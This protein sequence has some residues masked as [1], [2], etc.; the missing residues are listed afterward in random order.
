MVGDATRQFDAV[1][2]ANWTR[3]LPV[4]Q[5]RGLHTRWRFVAV[6]AAGGVVGTAARESLELVL[7]QSRFPFAVFT[8]NLLGAFLLGFL[9]EALA[10]RGADKGVRRVLRLGLGTGMLG[11]FTTYGTLALGVAGLAATLHPISLAHPMMLLSAGAYGVGTVVAGALAT[12]F[13]ILLAA[14][15]RPERERPNG[16]LPA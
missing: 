14:L 5:R 4:I 10:R 8:V 16:E 13:G 1:A 6:V 3:P 9:V 15:V 12:F 2:T 7:P 11:G